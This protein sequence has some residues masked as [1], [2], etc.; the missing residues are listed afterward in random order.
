[1][2]FDYSARNE[3]GFM[4]ID[5]LLQAFLADVSSERGLSSNTLAAYRNDIG[6]FIEFLKGRG[7]T[8]PAS[9]TDD[10]TIA[11]IAHLRRSGGKPATVTR[12]LTALRMFAQFLCR[13]EYCRFD[14]TAAV[15]LGKTRARRLPATL[16]TD[17]IDRLIAAPRRDTPEGLRDA[18]M[19]ELM[20]GS[21]LRVS[22]LISLRMGDLDLTSGV[23]R[24]FGKGNKER[25]A[26]VGERVRLLL[27][28]YVLNV[29]PSFRGAT[30]VVP[31]RHAD[32]AVFL[33][34]HGGPMTRTHFWRLIKEYATE[35]GIDKSISPH[36]LRHSFATHLLAGGADVRAIQEMMGHA[37][38][39]TTQRYTRVDVARLRKTYDAAHPRATKKE[40][41]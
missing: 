3:C 14:F 34:S 16:T 18:A 40:K 31:V 7:V 20:Y 29:R 15:D 28:E 12:R 38:V 33:T 23:V 22:E 27:G 37:S 25:Q 1:M 17:E 5:L 8:A 9:I 4:S 11:F 41:E 13:E 24:P 19:L 30:S 21:G 36:T 32:D 6:Q 26:P 35:T 2:L 10:E 39:E